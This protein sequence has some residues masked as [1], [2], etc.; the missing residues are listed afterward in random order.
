MKSPINIIYLDDNETKQDMLSIFASSTDYPLIITNTQCAS[1]ALEKIKENDYDY[2]ITDF[3]M[4]DINGSQFAYKV[5]SLPKK[6][7]PILG[8]TSEK[9]LELTFGDDPHIEKVF[10]SNDPRACLDH[11]INNFTARNIQ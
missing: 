1:D 11:I 7:P 6:T 4:P 9:N 2:I 5:K 10:F 3:H 8:Y